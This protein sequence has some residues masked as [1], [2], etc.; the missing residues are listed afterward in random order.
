MTPIDPGLDNI[1]MAIGVIVKK[2]GY[3]SRGWIDGLSE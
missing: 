2:F 1:G 3:T